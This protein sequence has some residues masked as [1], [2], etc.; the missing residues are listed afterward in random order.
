M[1]P[2][3]GYIEVPDDLL[4]ERTSQIHRDN[5]GLGPPDL[6]RVDKIQAK[7][8]PIEFF[9]HLCGYKI[10][11]P[12]SVEEYFALVVKL[13]SKTAFR[14]RRYKIRTCKFSCWNS[15]R[16][17]DVRIKVEDGKICKT[18][19]IG[20]SSPGDEIDEQTW[21][22]LGICS[23]LRFW[24]IPTPLF[25]SLYNI[26]P[27]SYP[28]L[29][30]VK[31]PRLSTAEIEYFV[32]H[33]ERSDSAELAL[34]G[35]FISLGEWREERELLS[36]VIIRTMPGVISWMFRLM[37][38]NSILSKKLM[39]Q[40]KRAYTLYPDDCRL[41]LTLVQLCEDM[42]SVSDCEVALPLL[43]GSM[44]SCPV[45]CC[46]MAKV[47]LL[48]RRQ[49]DCLYCLNAAFYSTTMRKSAHTPVT[50]V[51]PRVES[52]TAPR[53]RPN[54]I[55]RE[56]FESQRYDVDCLLYET[57]HDVVKVMTMAK[58][59]GV[60]KK[61]RTSKDQAISMGNEDI[62]KDEPA[63]PKHLDAE[64]EFLFDPGVERGNELPE[65]IRQL[66]LCQQLSRLLAQIADDFTIRD[67]TMN[68]KKWDASS[69]IRKALC[70]ALKLRD[71][72]MLHTLAPLV[73][74]S[75]KLK[76]IRQLIMFRLASASRWNSVSRKIS[77][78]ELTAHDKSMNEYNALTVV[79]MLADGINKLQT[80]PKGK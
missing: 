21:M 19:F 49:E 24:T 20:E 37:P 5:S 40:A 7:Y 27:V 44:W 69:E 72:Q 33:H 23:V 66:P 32:A 79:Y 26:S 29:R 13:R 36:T 14:V 1:K 61:F 60:L 10:D 52:Q 53:A 80:K 58:V 11:S 38:S 68:G 4:S 76:A 31:P 46:A 56:V 18:K 50:C 22:E 70:V 17:F 47:M 51:I 78:H 28:A 73:K 45:A 55:E 8:S 6:I 67:A 65:V 63:H 39:K 15:F 75:K 62:G 41:G 9:H 12:A 77:K 48:E 2:L 30:M 43:R 35:Y 54:P 57:L 59:R 3:S 64:L 34:A 42:D 16:S 71:F 74:S 25:R